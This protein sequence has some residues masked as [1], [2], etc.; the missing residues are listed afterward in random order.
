MQCRPHNVGVVTGVFPIVAYKTETG[1]GV[2]PLFPVKVFADHT[3][4]SFSIDLCYEHLAIALQ[5]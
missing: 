4:H 2:M 1:V 3:P 5:S